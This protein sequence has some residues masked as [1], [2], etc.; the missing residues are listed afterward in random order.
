MHANYISVMSSIHEYRLQILC[1]KYAINTVMINYYYYYRSR[2]RHIYNSNLN[3]TH[4]S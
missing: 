2:H 1:L 3:M 4:D